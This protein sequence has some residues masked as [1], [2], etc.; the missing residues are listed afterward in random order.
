[1]IVPQHDCNS[2]AVTTTAALEAAVER[3][4]EVVLL[5]GPYAGKKHT[6]SHPS[7]QLRWPEC[8]KKD[9]RVALAIRVDVLDIYVFEERTELIDHPCM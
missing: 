4:A 1:M 2:T 3:Q 6:I 8:E 9:I 5:Q 7:F